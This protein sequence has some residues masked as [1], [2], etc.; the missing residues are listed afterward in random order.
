MIELEQRVVPLVRGAANDVPDK[1]YTVAVINSAHDSCQ[2]TDIGLGT[3]DDEPVRLSGAKMLQQERLTEFGI[4]RLVD[5]PS[6]AER[7][8]RDPA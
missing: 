2:H 6:P 8:W 3:G 7:V 1:N 4:S 5:P